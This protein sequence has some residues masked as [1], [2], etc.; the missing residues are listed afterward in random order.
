MFA[1]QLSFSVLGLCF[2]RSDYGGLVFALHGG[3]TV[4]HPFRG[5]SVRPN[6]NPVGPVIRIPKRMIEVIVRFDRAHNRSLADRFERLMLESRAGGSDK[7]FDEQRSILS[8]Q[9]AAVAHGLDA[10]AGV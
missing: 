9:K 1:R 8:S 6:G 2:V 4:R 3:V 7:T 10:L 5:R